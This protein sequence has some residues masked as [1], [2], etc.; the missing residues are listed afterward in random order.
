MNTRSLFLLTAACLALALPAQ[1]QEPT[2]TLKEFIERNGQSTQEHLFKIGKVPARRVPGLATFAL[3][4]TGRNTAKDPALEVF[5]VAFSAPSK[6]SEGKLYFVRLYR[7]ESR[8]GHKTVTYSRRVTSSEVADGTAT[9]EAVRTAFAG[10]VH[11]GPA[12]HAKLRDA[13]SAIRKDADENKPAKGEQMTLSHEIS[14]DLRILVFKRGGKAD[15]GIDVGEARFFTTLDGL[16]KLGRLVGEAVDK[17]VELK[18][19]G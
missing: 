3:G 13:I 9:P 2:P 16:E 7:P 18:A 12:E 5:A 1:S 14:E 8:V 4:M 6:P 17:V 15:V 11:L 10:M 19:R